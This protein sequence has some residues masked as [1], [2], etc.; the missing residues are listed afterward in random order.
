MTDI[1]KELSAGLANIQS[2]LDDTYAIG[3]QTNR[4]L[5]DMIAVVE[6]DQFVNTVY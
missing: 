5:D 2:M 6:D 4:M 1:Y 3:A